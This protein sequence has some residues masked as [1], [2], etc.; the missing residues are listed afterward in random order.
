MHKSSSMKDDV[1]L[2]RAFDKKQNTFT[3]EP[4]QA[5]LCLRAFR[6]DKL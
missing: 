4:R 5:N 6:H 2:A 1:V 3:Y